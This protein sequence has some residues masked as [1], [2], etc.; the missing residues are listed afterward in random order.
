[1]S[2]SE[3]RHL[4]VTKHEWQMIINALD[5]MEATLH[6]ETVDRAV[7]SDLRS[8]F[9]ASQIDTLSRKVATTK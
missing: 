3:G 7:L 5:L 8:I 4:I 6:N 9:P 1:M 2:F